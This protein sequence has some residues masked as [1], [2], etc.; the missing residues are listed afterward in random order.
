METLKKWYFS[1][2]IKFKIIGAYILSIVIIGFVG[3][4]FYLVENIKYINREV[5]LYR[6]RLVDTQKSSVRSI[7]NVALDGIGQYYEDYKKGEL[8][9]SDAKAKAIKFV[10]SIRYNISKNMNSYDYVWIN[11]IDG[12]MILDP[13]KPTLNGKNVWDMKDKNGVYLFREMARVVKSQGGGFVKYCWVKLGD[14]S[15]KCYPKIS[16]VGYFYPWKWIVGSGFYLDEIDKAVQAY[17]KRK[18]HDIYVTM[19]SSLALGS[20]ISVIAALVFYYLISYITNYLKTIGELSEKLVHEEISPSLKLPY[21]GNDELGLLVQHFNK[22]V[23][24]SY[25]LMIF[26]KIIEDDVDVHAVYKRLFDLIKNEFNIKLFNIFEVDNSKH[27]MK[28]ISVY[29]DEKLFCKQDILVNCMLCR[30]VRTA[31]EV[32]SFIE[33]EIC[34]SFNSR[35]LK[36]HI[37]IPLLV[38]GSV[39]AVVQLVFSEEEKTEE[40]ERKIKRL[41]VF[42][43]EA[44]PVIEAKRLLERLRESTL[45]DPLTGLYNRRFLD[46]FAP[47]F[48]ATVKRRNTNAGILMCDIDFFKQ[49]NDVYGHNVGDEV[50]KGVVKAIVKSIRESDIAIRFGGEEFLVLLQDVDEDTAMEIAERIRADVENTELTVQGNVLKKTVSIGVSIFPKD[51]KNLWQCIKFSDVAMYKA[52]EAGRNRVVRFE[53]SMWTE[54]NY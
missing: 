1:R 16:Y 49:V 11:T 34:L 32:D 29:G 25:K 52:K 46:E 41:S 26:K 54:E 22:F 33:R 4:T 8:S 2:S 51:S 53:H 9:E 30:A 7:V 23:D 35:E 19:T 27:A 40:L 12:I 28:Q 45:R 48:V 10:Y 20:I 14:N 39:G 21:V 3:Y 24:D 36:N 42:L 44:A 6:Q 31:E 15:N 50:L 47:T 37:C 43:K 17:A 13:P 38:G 5:K 18:H